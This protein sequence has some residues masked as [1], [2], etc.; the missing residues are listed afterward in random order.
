[1]TMDHTTS[2]SGEIPFLTSREPVRVTRDIVYGEGGVEF[3]PGK[4]VGR[5]RTLRLDLY[6]PERP[7]SHPRPALVLAFGGAF[8]R[9]S[10]ET[11]E[12]GDAEGMSTP[13]SEYCRLFAERGYA[14]FSIDYRLTQE[15]PDPGVTPVLVPGEPMN[16]DRVNQVR[17]ILD[18]PPATDEE[19]A[20]GIEA[21][22]DDLVKAVYFI[23]S[24]SRS[25]NVDISRI[26]IGG[27]SA[28]AII[29]LNAAFIE[30][31]PVKAVISISG[32]VSELAR[33]S[34]LTG[35]DDEPAVL[36]FVGERD[37]QVILDGADET[38]AHMA[39]VG[40]R[41]SFVRVPGATHFY[42]RMTIVPDAEDRDIETTIVDFL[43]DVLKPR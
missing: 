25:Y 30:R 2:K 36:M 3:A 38:V 16:K 5:Y 1:M 23:R 41:H 29:S 14:C 40:I 26:A 34:C 9:G 21:A 20:N 31:V 15:K 22:T 37:L 19:L 42:P 27:F 32:R 7:T 35:A 33:N 39:R 11:D 6:E 8:H 28:G 13:V 17:A 10:K 24:R 4:G 18:L 43:Y 12:F